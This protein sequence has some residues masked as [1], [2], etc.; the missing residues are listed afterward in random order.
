MRLVLSLLAVNF[1]KVPKHMKIEPNQRLNLDT[2]YVARRVF[3]LALRS[4][5]E[6]NYHDSY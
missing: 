1:F 2:T 3:S 6:V 5:K 4:Q